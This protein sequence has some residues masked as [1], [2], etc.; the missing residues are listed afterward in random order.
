MPRL[1]SVR[2][3]QDISIVGKLSRPCNDRI[4][5]LQADME[6]IK[7]VISNIKMIEDKN[8]A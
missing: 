2:C 6:A 3:V 8:G 7:H 1:S 5:I 4:V